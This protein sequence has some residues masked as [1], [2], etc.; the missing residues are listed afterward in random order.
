MGNN[1]WTSNRFATFWALAVLLVASCLPIWQAWYFCH[2]G[3]VARR[4][5]FWVAFDC[6]V[7]AIDHVGVWNSVMEYHG[8]NWT[9]TG[10]VLA[11]GFLVGKL[12]YRSWQRP[13]ASRL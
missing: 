9:L 10:V 13:A 4:E 12:N 3:G 8:I 1:P 11:V 5:P 2:C 6:T 7:R